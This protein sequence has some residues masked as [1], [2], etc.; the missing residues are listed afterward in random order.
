MIEIP[1]KGSGDLYEQL[2]GR[3]GK[4]GLEFVL[5]MAHKLNELEKRLDSAIIP[6][7]WPEISSSVNPPEVSHAGSKT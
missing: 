5:E 4:A 7:E 1:V 3:F 2:Q 6:V